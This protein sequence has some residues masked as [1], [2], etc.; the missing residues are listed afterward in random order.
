M[1]YSMVIQWSDEDSTY[2]VSFPEW[3][4]TGDYYVHTHGDTYEEAVHNGQEL[5][6][7]L[8]ARAREDSKT[9]PAP[10]VFATA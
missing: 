9:L 8:I 10:Q 5:L 1:H 7:D 3:E 2:V 6:A 4:A